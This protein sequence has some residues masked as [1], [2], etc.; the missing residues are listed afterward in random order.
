[1]RK[2]FVIFAIVGIIVG[3]VLG[4]IGTTYY[5]NEDVAASSNGVGSELRSQI[6]N[7][8]WVVT[9]SATKFEFYPYWAGSGTLTEPELGTFLIDEIDKIIY[10]TN[11]PV[12]GSNP[13]FYFTIYTDVDGNDDQS[14]WYGYRLNVEPYFSNSLNAPANTWN[15]WNTDA[16]NNQLTFFDSHKSL[17]YG[18]YGQPDLQ[19]LQSGTINWSTLVAGGVDQD[20][21]Y[22][23]ETVKGICI[24]TGS[25]WSDTFNGYIDAIEIRL[26]NGKV[27][28]LDLEEK[29]QNVYVDGNYTGSTLGQIVDGHVFGSDAFATVGDG[30]EKART[31]GTVE[32]AY[33]VY[34]VGIIE[35]NKDLTISGV[36]GFMGI[37][38]VI[39]PT[40][41]TGTAYVS[42]PTG[43]GWF[44]ITGG[45][46]NIENF[47]INGDGKNIKIGVYFMDTS[48]GGSVVN[49]DFH[50][51]KHSKYIGMAIANHGSATDVTQNLSVINTTFQNIERIG[52]WTKFAPA[53]TNVSGGSYLGKGD[54][55]W[56]DYGYEASG[57]GIITVDDVFVRWCTGV[58]ASDGSTS[59]G[60]LATTYW[61]AGTQVTITNSIIKEN[62][63]GIFVGYDA[64][65]ES[66]VE[67]HNNHIFDNV[68]FG[69][70][71]TA[72]IVDAM[73]NWW[74][75]ASGPYHATN[76]GGVGN[77]VS[78]YVLFNPRS[79]DENHETSLSVD[80]VSFTATQNGGTVVLDWETGAEVNN[81]GFIVERKSVTSDWTQIASYMD[82]EALIGAG[83][84]S[85]ATSY[86]FTDADVVGGMTYDYRITDVDYAGVTKTHKAV[87]ITLE[88]VSKETPEK[89]ILNAAYPNPFNPTTTISYGINEIANVN[90]SIYD[91]NGRLVETLV[92]EQKEVGYHNIKWNASNVSSGVYIYKINVDGKYTD[93]KRCVLMK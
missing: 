9:P 85:E 60:I 6:G 31:S 57:G 25:G 19:D 91:M 4:G 62:S 34:N 35:I 5:L 16:G 86:S 3:N 93:M 2:F 61:G 44:Q 33:G 20:I 90:I 83:N 54:G 81:Q 82:C 37:K 29:P 14:S 69:I 76:A 23:L 77:D 53:F 87:S 72:P 84:S 78:D 65:D 38:P 36:L 55:D 73:N 48:N 51:I 26:T 80:L 66:V 70:F 22:G 21:D 41:N 49:C 89:F 1:M 10:H 59:A 15:Q 28:V 75:D 67:A 17:T 32:V 13:D 45:T 11:K 46:V 18:F 47:V 63:T 79:G 92:N 24:S 42:G 68:D 12:D 74:G 52:V 88:E 71:S 50:N 40:E 64:G 56:I 7:G 39:R 30:V 43:A 8:S 58:A 27:A